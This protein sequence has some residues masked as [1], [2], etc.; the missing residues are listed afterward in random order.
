MPEVLRVNGYIVKIWFNDHPPQHV[1]VFK[2]NGECII[3][4]NNQDG[5]PTLIKFQNMSRQEVSKALKLVNKYQEQLLQMW[6][7]IHGDSE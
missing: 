5:L 3:E 2:N 6:Q 4:L 7:T 1:H